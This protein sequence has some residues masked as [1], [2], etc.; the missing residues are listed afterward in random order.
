MDTNN[1]T[2]LFQERDSYIGKIITIPKIDGDLLTFQYE[3]LNK[4]RL[5]SVYY[6]QSFKEK[7][8]LK[9]LRVG[10]I[11]NIKGTLQRPSSATNF[12]GFDYQN[13][14]YYQHIHWIFIPETSFFVKC[15]GKEETIIEKI[16]FFRQ[17]GIA[18]IQERLDP[19][20]VGIVTALIFGERYLLHEQVLHAYQ[21]LGLV[22]LLAVSGLHVGLITGTIYFL[23]IR[24]GITKE[25]S[26]D[27]LLISLPVYML[28]AGAAPSVLRAS[29]TTMVV[30][31]SI[32]VKNKIHPLDGIS[33]VCLG[34]LFVNPYYVYHIGFQ[35]SFIVSYGLI[36]SSRII[37]HSR[38]YW[39]KLFVVTTI[40]QLSSLPIILYHFYEVS[41]LSLPLNLLYIPL[42]S[43]FILPLSF[44]SFLLIS[45]LPAISDPLLSTFSKVVKL[46]HELLLLFNQYSFFTIRTG[47]LLPIL[48]L[49]FYLA[50]CYLLLKWEQ[51]GHFRKLLPPIIVCILIIAG[52]MYFP[53]FSRSGVV[54]FLDVGQGDCIVLELPYRK[55]VYVIDTGGLV[56]FRQNEEWRERNRSFDV[57]KDIVL[58]YLKARGVRKIDRLILTHGHFDHIGGTD[59]LLGE[60]RIEEVFYSKG[61][62]EGEYE[63]ELLTRLYQAGSKLTFT[64]EGD[65]WS[66]GSSQF[67]ILSPIGNE[68]SL[69]N[70]SIVILAQLGGLNWLFTGDLE[71]DGERRLIRDYPNLNVDI[72]KAGHHGSRT[73]STEVFIEQLDPKIVIISAGRA[74]RFGH[75]HREVIERYT[76]KAIKIFRT[77]EN[78]AIRFK[79]KGK[80]GRFETMLQ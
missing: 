3:L 4:E 34:L 9:Y 77:D 35:L 59:A 53:Y 57:G 65:S 32:R 45:L 58:P 17:L 20:I 2:S 60:I 47:K 42:I 25:R 64:S 54:T 43:L 79:Y 1:Q 21:A 41:L 74:N 46:S 72:L 7:E 36:I 63:K 80:K 19:D 76:N 11:C 28:V 51:K 30:L 15:K 56:S 69:N 33:I 67:F 10:M 48:L 61:K 16:Q 39:Q 75:P 73:S 52:Q 44:V 38:S 23:L 55:Q 37:L 27:M 8:Q 49:L 78:G 29:I 40:S 70:R 22:H 24:I 6:I 18:R 68:E 26:I 13:Y 5:Q 71:E 12:Y 31:L 62:I 50:I 14:L 66:V